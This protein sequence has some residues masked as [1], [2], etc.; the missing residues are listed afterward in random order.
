VASLLSGLMKNGRIWNPPL[1]T[2]IKNK[3][4]S[5][6][7]FIRLVKVYIQPKADESVSRKGYK[8]NFLF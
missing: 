6:K 7:I 4:D 3:D 5:N 1:Q 2:G 8:K